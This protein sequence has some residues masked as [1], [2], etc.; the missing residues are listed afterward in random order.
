[1]KTNTKSSVTLPAET[2]AVVRSL[3]RRL[4]AKSNVEVV[5]RGLEL[6]RKQVDREAMREAYRQAASAA[7]ETTPVELASLDHLAGENLED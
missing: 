5:R 6:L 2:L 7:R 1:M 3:R 4:G